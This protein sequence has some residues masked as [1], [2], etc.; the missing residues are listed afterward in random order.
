MDRTTDVI[1]QLLKKFNIIDDPSRF[2]LYERDTLS[3]KQKSFWVFLK[4]R[5]LLMAARGLP[6]FAN[7]YEVLWLGCQLI[8]CLSSDDELSLVLCMLLHCYCGYMLFLL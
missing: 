2:V 3:S 5:N 4:D 7:V 6:V 1:C 8:A